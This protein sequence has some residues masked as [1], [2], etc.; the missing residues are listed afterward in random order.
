MDEY[1][2]LSEL[3]ESD[4]HAMAFY[5]SLSMSLRRKIHD[6]GV[7]SF[8]SLYKSAKPPM[9]GAVPAFDGTSAMNVASSNEMTG[10]VPAGSDLRPEQWE[11]ARGLMPTE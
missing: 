7:S 9:F 4:K 1:K 11:S 6:G 2:D 3:L 10:A 8:M 5:N